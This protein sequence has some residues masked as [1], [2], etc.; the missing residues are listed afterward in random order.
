MVSTP[1]YPPKSRIA[2]RRTRRRRRLRR[3]LGA[4]V[5]ELR[6]PATL[7]LIACCLVVGIPVAIYSTPGQHVVTI[8]QHLTVG[9]RT[10]DLSLSGPAQ[11]VQIGNTELDIPRLHVY[12]PLRPQIV[13]GPVQRSPAAA[14][15]LDPTVSGQS[16]ADA[17]GTLGEGFLRWYG[18]GALSA[19]VFALGAAAVAGCARMLITLR[20][21]SRRGVGHRPVTEIWHQCSRQISRMTVLAVVVT[22]AGW[23]TSGALAYAGAAHGLRGVDSLSELVGVYHVSPSPVGPEVSG[24][25]GAVVGDSRAARVGGPLP[26]DAGPDDVACER[27]SDSLAAE[28]GL[29]LPAPVLNLACPSATIAQGLRG[30]QQ[31]GA[32]EVA[33]QVGLLKQVQDLDFVVLVIGPNDLGWTDFI[34]Y[35]YA[36]E[37]CSDN[38]TQGEFAYRL[39]AFDREY[40][41]LLRDLNDLPDRPQVIVMR[42]YD[43]FEPAA[44]C[45]DSRGPLQFSGL[46]P[47]EIEL[48]SGRN[49]QLNSILAAGAGKYGFDVAD[50]QLAPLCAPTPDG[51]DPDLQGLADAHPFH[52]TGMGTV[53]MASSVVRLVAP[54]DRARDEP[55]RRG[56]P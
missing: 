31:R 49:T 45:P 23:G 6:S 18:W 40:G 5:R 36:V 47:A 27:S 26:P 55:T 4:L 41:E 53:R 38:L 52:P 19:L 29:L 46:S 24:Y 16:Q 30:P 10:P 50:P 14:E 17:T 51:L 15:A 28:V 25:R 2:A 1:T 33:P 8:G 20:R 39:A 56:G 13:M 48:L 32:R 21:Q 3:Q 12:G 54:D 34:K 9:A 11:L 42:S 22:L 35:C 37:N 7:A 44:N 43:V